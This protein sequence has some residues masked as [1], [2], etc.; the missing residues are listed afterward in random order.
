MRLRAFLLPL[1]ALAMAPGWAAAQTSKVP[2]SLDLRGFRASTDPS[3]GVYYEPA[4]SPGHL[5]AN[6]AAW[7]SYAG[8]QIALREPGTG[9]VVSAP[10]EH[11]F[12]GDVAL[13]VGLF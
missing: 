11:S 5:E 7:L 4:S 3:S 10:L 13:N 8:S 6:G 1:F 9:A 12:T 2:P